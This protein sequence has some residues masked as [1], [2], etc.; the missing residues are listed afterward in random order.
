MTVYNVIWLFV[1]LKH[2]IEMTSYLFISNYYFQKEEPH[3]LAKLLSVFCWLI[4]N[5]KHKYPDR[6]EQ[7]ANAI[8]HKWQ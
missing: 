8:P 2:E 5:S 6:A 1:F 7:I 4:Q 3:F